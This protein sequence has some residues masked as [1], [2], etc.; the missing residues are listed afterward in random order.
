MLE[1]K[2]SFT[3]NTIYEFIPQGYY[4]SLNIETIVKSFYHPNYQ[5]LLIWKVSYFSS[6]MKQII[7][8]KKK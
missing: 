7:L 3:E 2:P 6:V 5:I 8:L 4:T 1:E